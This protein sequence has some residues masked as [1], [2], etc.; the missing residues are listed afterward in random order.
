MVGFIGRET[1]LQM[2]QRRYDSGKFECVVV[3]GRR[4]IGKTA[5][6]NRFVQ[7]KPA[8]F[9]TATRTALNATLK[10]SA[11]ASRGTATG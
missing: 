11:P 6:I 4:R 5:L 10:G 8:I 1:E 9:Y 7:D 2:L 3:Y